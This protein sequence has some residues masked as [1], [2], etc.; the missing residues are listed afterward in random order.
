MGIQAWAS[1]DVGRRRKVNEDSFLVDPELGLY[2]VADGMGGDASGGLASSRC[3]EVVRR[4]IAQNGAVTAAFARGPG[5]EARE[6]AQALMERAIQAACAE[7]HG[8]TQQD[9]QKRG[10]RTTCV[11]LL[12]CGSRAVIGHVGDSRAYLLRAGRVHQLTE[13]H[14]LVQEQFKRGLITK[15]E[16]MRSPMHIVTRAV[17][18]QPSVQVDTLA[19]DVVPG[20]LL[21]L[22]TDGLHGYLAE[23]ELASL[24]SR[25]PRATLSQRLVE[26]ANERG[27]KD[28]VTVVA[29]AI[30]ASAPVERDE[31]S[32]EA[33]EIDARTEM[34]RRIPLFQYMN[35]KELLAILSIA[36][37]R[38][39]AAGEK[40]V[41]EGAGSD[42]MFVVS[43]GRVEVSKAGA[44]IATVRA[45]GHFGEM[46][47]VDQAPRSATVVALEPTHAIA[48]GRDGLLKLMRKDSLLAV[49]LLWSFTQSLSERLRH[50]NDAFTGLK[51]EVERLREDAE[52]RN[53]FG[54][55]D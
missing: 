3:T 8:L 55:E 21:V 14:T 9:P 54:A 11:A 19:T 20:D 40:V 36:R 41:E 10:I 42:E 44:V 35:Y 53:P 27:G 50:T 26:L 13:D 24:F 38:R 46:G 29:A 49:K 12:V 28:N 31:S 16:A 6:A 45:G 48:L 34:L 4:H 1:T 7:I 25:E 17:G 47:L 30:T 43:R 23:H 18:L 22:C 37:I 32:L 2:I 39:Y 52:A 51:S 5:G 33:E 15:Q